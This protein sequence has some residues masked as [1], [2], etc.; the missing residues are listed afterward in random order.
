LD[1]VLVV[2]LS[3][4]ASVVGVT[5]VEV[6]A[7][8]APL[9][10]LAGVWGANVPEV[11]VVAIVLGTAP[12]GVLGA[13]VLVVEELLVL[14]GW[15]VGPGR[16][17]VVVA[18]SADVLDVVGTVVV[19][20]P[21]VV[22]ELAGVVVVVTPVVD[23]GTVVVVA[24]VVVV[25][26][27]P[28]VVVAAVVVVTDEVGENV[29]DGTDV[30]SALAA[31]FGTTKVPSARPVANSAAPEVATSRAS[32]LL[33]LWEDKRIRAPNVMSPVGSPSSPSNDVSSIWSLGAIFT[34]LTS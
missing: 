24:G 30:A 17:V 33:E 28:V 2:G 22:V 14:V 21:V 18:G 25:K 19:V 12:G 34:V 16:P 26:P 27:A 9:A 32:H 3:M 7:E 4:P 29:G 10:V 11:E 6:V 15:S 31:T 20:T 23:V 8:V 13:V 1:V 5:E